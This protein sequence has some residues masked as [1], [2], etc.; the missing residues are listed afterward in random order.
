M[1]VHDAASCESR[2]SPVGCGSASAA[3]PTAL[4]ARIDKHLEARWAAEKVKPPTPADDAA[5]VRRVYLDLVGRIPTAAEARA[6]ID[7]KAAD[8]RAK[9]V[10]SARRVGGPRATLGDRLAARVD[11]PGLEEVINVGRDSPVCG[12]IE[13]NG[14]GEVIEYEPRG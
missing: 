2:Y 10:G 4:A 7:D 8:K 3:D 11:F 14:S 13:C 9:L 1:P 6:F 5:F 12:T